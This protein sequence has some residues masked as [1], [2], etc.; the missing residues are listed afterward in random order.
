MQVIGRAVVL[1]DLLLRKLRNRKKQPSSSQTS[2]IETTGIHTR[3]G[4]KPSLVPNTR[5][6][7]LVNYDNASHTLWRAQEFTLFARNRSLLVSPILDLGC[8]DG[9]F[10]SI[11]FNKLEYGIDPDPNAIEIAKTL[12]IYGVLLN[13]PAEDTQLQNSSIRSV[14]SNSVLEHATNL[15]A[16][17]KEMSRII[18]PGGV[19]MLTVPNEEFTT[20]MSK[21]F[22]FREAQRLNENEFFHRNLL[23]NE[24][25]TGLLR[26]HDFEIIKL[27]N[28]QP[29]NLNFVFRL[30]RSPIIR[31]LNKIIPLWNTQD[32]LNLVDNSLK[33]QKGQERL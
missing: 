9:S 16:I 25:W 10:S 15:D 1:M 12:N 5:E 22:G 32:I 24:Q 26:K 7:F 21:L 14:F 20:S 27:Q 31:R 33:C 17:I 18:I 2:G 3:P 6:I 30:L 19:F 4:I 11:L 8:G 23:S 28:Y 13:R 29:D